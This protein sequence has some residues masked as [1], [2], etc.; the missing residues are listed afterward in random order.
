MKKKNSYGICFFMI[1]GILLAGIGLSADLV[2]YTYLPSE[3]ALDFVFIFN[4]EPTHVATAALDYGRYYEITLPGVLK[5]ETDINRFLGYS[6]VVGFKANSGKGTIT[7]RFDMLL[8]R[9]PELVIV[10]N[11]LRVTFPRNTLPIKELSSYSDTSSS[12]TRPPLTSLLA[13][14]RKYLDVNLV[15]DEAS[16]RGLQ[17]EF[18]M[19]ADNLRAEDFFFQ[20]MMNNP[21]LGYAFLPNNTVY[22]V[23]KELIS[24]KVN[25]ILKEVSLSPKTELSYWAS[26]NFNLKKES[27]LFQMFSGYENATSQRIFN[28]DAFQ[29]FLIEEFGNKYAKL[30]VSIQNDLI[31]LIRGKSTTEEVSIGILLYGNAGLQEKFEFF[32][33]F[34]EG[35]D[36]SGIQTTATSTTVSTDYTQKVVYTPLLAEEVRAFMNFYI[37]VVKSIY[38]ANEITVQ[39]DTTTFEIQ[40][41]LS[42]VFLYGQEEKV[43]KLAQY[44]NNYIKDRKARG[45][46]KMERFEV[47]DG[48]GKIFA[49][50]L[51]RTFPKAIVNSDGL[52]AETVTVKPTFEWTD[53][54]LQKLRS[55]DGKP[56]EITIL[57]SNYEVMTA[58][59]IADDWGLLV[60]PLESEIR[61]IV[62]SENLPDNA[63]TALLNPESPNSL[64]TKFPSAQFDASFEPLIIVRGKPQDLDTIAG[65]LAELEQVWYKKPE[66]VEVVN[67]SQELM[68][69]EAEKFMTTSVSITQSEGSGNSYI[70]ATGETPSEGTFTA[71]STSTSTSGTISH[72]ELGQVNVVSSNLLAGQ[73]D[74]AS[75]I[76]KRWPTVSVSVI[77]FLNMFILRGENQGDILAAK[78]ELE[79]LDW[80]AANETVYSELTF[81]EHLEASN[82]T[83]IW[84]QFYMKHNVKIIFI[85]SLGAYKFYGPEKYVRAFVEELQEIDVDRIIGQPVVQTELVLINITA[86]PVDEVE[87]LLQI[88]V[89]ECTLEIFGSG[90]YFITGTRDQIEKAKEVLNSLSTDFMEDTKVLKLSA[91]ISKQ[92]VSDVLQLYYKQE[93]TYELLE[94]GNS[95]VL[96]K[97]QKE[98]LEQMIKVLTSYGL[99]EELNPP[100]PK[101]KAETRMITLSSDFPAEPLTVLLDPKSPNSL[102]S[103]YPTVQFDASFKPLLIITGEQQDLN[104]IETYLTELEQVWR[105][106][107]VETVKVSKI[108]MEKEAAKF[109][110][111]RVTQYVNSWTNAVSE[112]TSSSS[113]TRESPLSGNTSANIGVSSSATASILGNSSQDTV[114]GG[115]LVV[116]SSLLEGKGDTAQYLMKRWGDIEVSVVYYLDTFIIKG[117]NQKTV[118]EA[119]TELEQIDKDMNIPEE[120][121]VVVH[122][123]ETDTFDIYS[124]NRLVISLTREIA[125]LLEPKKNLYIPSEETLANSLTLEERS[126]QMCTLEM[127]DLTWEK[128]IQIIE[129]LYDYRVELIDG[130]AEPIYVITPPRVEHQIGLSKNRV[131]NISHGFEEVASLISSPMFGGQVYSDEVNGVV[132]FTNIS[133]SKMTQLKPMIAK[134]VQPKKMVEIKALVIDST[135]LDKLEKDMQMTLNASPTMILSSE[136]FSFTGNLLDLANTTKLLTALTRDLSVD[137]NFNMT[138]TNTDGD[139]LLNPRITTSSGKTASIQVAQTLTVITP[140]GSSTSNTSTVQSGYRLQITPTVRMD[141]TIY[142]VVDVSDGSA[143]EKGTSANFLLI[144]DRSTE[145]QTEVVLKNGETLL[146]GGLKYE[147][148]SKTVTKIPFFG[149]LPFLGQFFRKETENVNNRTID[150]LITP[151][152]IDVN[153]PQDNVFGMNT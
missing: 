144:E 28:K 40:D 58:Q 123:N 53:E 72:I 25:E 93:N 16:I 2:N 26:Y 111:T 36:K 34:F 92:T 131:L 152:I 68:A 103:R 50:A 142:L 14:L 38:A 74:T 55:Y 41:S 61:M 126:R 115:N 94:L 80:E 52:S 22:V 33:S 45:N 35:M 75:Y 99:V 140:A 39:M 106:T 76:S 120:P 116:A 117:K 133:D 6:P 90:G 13:V 135:Y 129:R 118:S 19:L 113:T 27:E 9:E 136:G 4:N 31:V 24:A 15:I 30:S 7:L 150:I 47:K 21:T 147:G 73:G 102:V 88:K 17:A 127:K 143:E 148:K 104:A 124:R 65:Y 151:T 121:N 134:I 20:I 69:K 71:Q 78:E 63:R 119:R 10:A 44:L 137:M 87:K 23:R 32:M 86:L 56:D 128:W 97:S 67:V 77:Y 81:F 108:L 83:L 101:Q 60:P 122:K 59:R 100:D 132:I 107:Y 114:F 8:P 51:N 153:I 139:Y 98:K 89:P 12:G 29:Q 79:K 57:G 11:T 5:G 96:I 91:G 48:T 54:E 18:V 82:I 145:A 141:G 1:L 49:V 70:R 112:G 3:D 42:T 130:L 149:D 125:D 62:L 110:E 105:G 37:S 138:K 66:Y 146:I 46:E 43:K 84:E 85:E 95:R 109:Q 64:I